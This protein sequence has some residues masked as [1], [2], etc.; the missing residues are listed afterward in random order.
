[1][2]RYTILSLALLA[3]CVVGHEGHDDHSAVVYT[4]VMVM[5]GV[6]TTMAM[7]ADASGHDH[8]HGESTPTSAA[9]LSTSSSQGLALPT[10]VPR[11]GVA[12][13]VAAALAGVGI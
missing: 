6:T 12:G 13:L 5:D 3:A 11:I 10:S 9:A 4:T 1:M 2:F 7:T 8:G